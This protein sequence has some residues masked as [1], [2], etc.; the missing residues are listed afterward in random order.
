[1][2]VNTYQTIFF[3]VEYFAPRIELAPGL[4]TGEPRHFC[5]GLTVREQRNA[6]MP[7]NLRPNNKKNT[8][9]VLQSKTRD[10]GQ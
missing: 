7:K 5:G 9:I 2:F 1:M 8:E 10:V 3:N 6:T 4:W